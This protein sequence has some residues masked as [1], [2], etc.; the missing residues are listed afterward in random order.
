MTVVRV[1][2]AFH[3]G[4][5]LGVVGDLGRALLMLPGDRYVI[6]VYFICDMVGTSISDLM[7]VIYGYEISKLMEPKKHMETL[8]ASQLPI[9]DQWIDAWIKAA[10]WCI[11][12]GLDNFGGGFAGNK[13]ETIYY[14][15]TNLKDNWFHFSAF[16]SR[17]QEYRFFLWVGRLSK[18]LGLRKSEKLKKFKE[19]MATGVK[20][21][22][23]ELE[24]RMKLSNMELGVKL[25]A[26]VLVDQQLNKWGNSGQ[27]GE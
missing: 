19:N 1:R 5:A 27:L 20:D 6:E 8:M 24:S 10:L 22:A 26:K 3:D 4:Q 23:V 11:I 9:T 18:N 7:V 13:R 25:I 12:V 14:T 2:L 16:Y 21:P 15:F 17:E